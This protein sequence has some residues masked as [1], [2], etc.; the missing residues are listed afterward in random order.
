MTVV[1]RDARWL[2]LLHKYELNTSSE[3]PPQ[4][5]FDTYVSE[6]VEPFSAGDASG[7]NGTAT[8]TSD[9]WQEAV[10]ALTS[11]ELNLSDH[12]GVVLPLESYQEAWDGLRDGRYFNVL[13]LAS[14][15]LESV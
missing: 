5:G 15:E 7:G 2:K 6:D 1:E 4:N 3:P 10:R 8:A 13:L 11:G 14:K 12:I 9:A